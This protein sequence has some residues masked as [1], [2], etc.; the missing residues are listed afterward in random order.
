MTG[1]KNLGMSEDSLIRNRWQFRLLRG[2]I[3]I[4]FVSAA[5]LAGWFG[6]RQAT[7]V[8]AIQRLGS[9]KVIGTP[10]PPPGFRLERIG[11]PR[12][13]EPVHLIVAPDRNGLWIVE[14]RGRI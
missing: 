2:G 1:F 12:L 4:L 10:E 3:V 6:Y 8:A 11:S 7:A 14:R 5:A 13:K 9:S